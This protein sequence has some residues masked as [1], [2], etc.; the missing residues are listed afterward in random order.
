M[1]IKP[2]IDS[3]LSSLRFLKIPFQVECDCVEILHVFCLPFDRCK[4][5]VARN[6]GDRCSAREDELRVGQC[7]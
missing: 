1:H 4:G 3:I 6:S 7:S 2:Y 5:C